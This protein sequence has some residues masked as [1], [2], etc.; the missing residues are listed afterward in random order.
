MAEPNVLILG[1]QANHLIELTDTVRELGFRAIRAKTPQDAIAIS[2]ERG[3]RY[4]TVLLDTEAPMMDVGAALDTLRRECR[5]PGMVAIAT[6]ERPSASE[7]DRL[8]DG[9]IE[10]AVWLPVRDHAL[11][12]HLSD[13]CYPD[14]PGM[15]QGEP[16]AHLG[17]MARVMVGGRSKLAQVYALSCG[18]AYLITDRPSV[19]GSELVLELPLPQGPMHLECEVTFTNVPGNLRRSSLPTGMCV[20]FLRTPA[21]DLEAIRACVIESASEYTV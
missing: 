14:Q 7:R 1:N 19:R 11:L 4:D 18:G 20:E 12:C 2:Q 5:S 10:H 16:R 21:A 17:W 15:L 3:H 6:G 13:A 8:R 9:G